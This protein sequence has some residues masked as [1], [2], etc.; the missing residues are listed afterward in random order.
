MTFKPY[1]LFMLCYRMSIGLSSVLGLGLKTTNYLLLN[2]SI[3]FWLLS[4]SSYSLKLQVMLDLSRP[5]AA[6]QLFLPPG[7]KDE[8]DFGMVHF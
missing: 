3:C 2:P 4:R 7:F 5:K 8:N 1:F 6:K